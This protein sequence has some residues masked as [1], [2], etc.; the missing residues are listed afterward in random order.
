VIAMTLKP[1]SSLDFEV[2]FE[3]AIDNL[4]ATNTTHRV[5][6]TKDVDGTDLT[7]PVK[8]DGTTVILL[9]HIKTAPSPWGVSLDRALV[10]SDAQKTFTKVGSG[11]DITVTFDTV[12]GAIGGSQNQSTLTLKLNNNAVPYD[13][14]VTGVGSMDAAYRSQNQNGV[15]I[16]AVA[17][18]VT[19]PA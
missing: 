13:L 17:Y 10:G 5:Y 19:R 11:W 4:A 1:E 14:T 16:T 12:T 6:A 3:V 7:V 2:E 9:D 8:L 18:R 15:T